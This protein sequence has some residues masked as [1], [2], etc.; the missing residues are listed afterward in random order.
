MQILP[1]SGGWMALAIVPFKAYAIIVFLI[2]AAWSREIRGQP[3]LL[4]LVLGYGAC[5]VVLLA[6]AIAQR[7]GGQHAP[8]VGTFAWGVAVL[9]L[10]FAFAWRWLPTLAE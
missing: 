10:G 9:V 2:A 6:A 5:V 1:Q 8:A 4:F 3:M 7:V